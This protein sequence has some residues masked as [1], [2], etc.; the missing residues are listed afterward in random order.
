M[1]GRGEERLSE[2]CPIFFIS[3]GGEAIAVA[4]GACLK[5]VKWIAE[6]TKKIRKII[7]NNL[8]MHFFLRI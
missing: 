1:G 4:S 3:Q 5:V 8:K 6:L 2:K 7:F